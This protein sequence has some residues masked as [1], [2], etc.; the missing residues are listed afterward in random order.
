MDSGGEWIVASMV[1][2]EQPW[3]GLTKLV[4]ML[5]MA[6]EECL[7]GQPDIDPLNT[8][9][10]LCVAEINRPGR[11]QSIEQELLTNLEHELGVQFHRASTFIAEGRVSAAVALQYARGLLYQHELPA[12]IIAGVDSL[13]VGPTLAAL[14]DGER[15][16][17]S[18]N[19]D[20]FIP[21]EAAAAVLV[22]IPKPTP[23]PQ[24][25]CLGLGFG[26]EKAT[27]ES[28]LPLRADGLTQ[29]IKAALVE[30]GVEMHS[31]DYRIT[32]VS[33]EQY[34]F[35]EASLAVSRTLRQRKEEFDI[36][37]PADCIGETGA[38]IGPAILTVALAAN[39]KSYSISDSFFC[40]LGND[41]GKRAALIMNYQPVRM[42]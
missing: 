39:R 5:S 1:P 28:E 16:L 11:I 17:T 20:G 4:K 19:S 31:L 27:I 13:L 41:D 22:K 24:L 33:G 37:H 25:L 10:L 6:V 2:L 32:D 14:E 30:V 29:A 36:W 23:E 34:C 8:P 26:D 40:H 18:K 35:K 9:L 12:V 42:G 7:T 3:R 15:L 38:A 21:G